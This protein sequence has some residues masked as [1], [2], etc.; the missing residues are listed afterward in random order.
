MATK[1]LPKKI[2]IFLARIVI[3]GLFSTVCG[4]GLLSSSCAFTLCMKLLWHDHQC[5]IIAVAAAVAH[6]VGVGA[7]GER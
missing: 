4:A 7:Y 6:L 3:Y 5:E 1:M 2:G